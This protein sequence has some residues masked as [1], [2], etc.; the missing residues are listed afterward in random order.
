MRGYFWAIS[1]GLI[2]AG[3]ISITNLIVAKKPD[4]KDKLD[5]LTDYSGYIGSV[6]LLAGIWGLVDGLFISKFYTAHVGA[7]MKVVPV[8]A[9]AIF[10][11][12]PLCIVLGLLQGLPKI[13]EWT[14]KDLTKVEEMAKKVAP[15]SVPFGIAGIAVGFLLLLF[16]LGIYF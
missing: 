15:F 8:Q 13:A 5:K 3:I 12:P 11:F 6:I 14:G 2:A 1:L 7:F 4:L 10:L 9:I 16:L